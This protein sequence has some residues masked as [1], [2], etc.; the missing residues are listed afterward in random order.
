MKKYI[1]IEGLQT[2]I[3]NK[4]N[5]LERLSLYKYWKVWKNNAINNYAK[6]PKK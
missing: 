1:S 6:K 2:A 3:T 4:I 5:V